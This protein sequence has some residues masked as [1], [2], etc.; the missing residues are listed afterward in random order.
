MECE[1]WSAGGIFRFLG[2]MKRDYFALRVSFM[3]ELL[4]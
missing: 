2:G 4:P 3:F 1:N